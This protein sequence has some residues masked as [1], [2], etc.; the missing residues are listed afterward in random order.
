VAPDHV[1]AAPQFTDLL[2]IYKPPLSD[3]IRRDEKMAS[4]VVFLQ[5]VSHTRVGA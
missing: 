2:A 5:F 4:P 3:A 1:T